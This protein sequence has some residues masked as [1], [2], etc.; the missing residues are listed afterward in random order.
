MTNDCALERHSASGL[1]GTGLAGLADRVAA[2]GGRL[3]A[4][5]LDDGFGLLVELPLG[6]AGTLESEARQ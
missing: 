1:L 5:P 6:R 4:R 3:E 2:H